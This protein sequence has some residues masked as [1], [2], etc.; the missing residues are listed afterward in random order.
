MSTFAPVF[1]SQFNILSMVMLMLM[2][3]MGIEP[4]LCI[5]ILL[6]LHSNIF[7]NANTDVDTKCQ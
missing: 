6:P 4:I 5:Q 7:K 3:R 2:Q 1:A